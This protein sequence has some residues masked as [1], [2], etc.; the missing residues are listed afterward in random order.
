MRNWLQAF[1]RSVLIVTYKCADIHVCNVYID[2]I[3]SIKHEQACLDGIRFASITNS[4]SILGWSMSQIQ[5]LLWVWV[6]VHQWAK[7]RAECRAELEQF[8]IVCLLDNPEGP[9]PGMVDIFWCAN[10]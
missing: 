1:K 5:A 9:I 2:K 7:I 4:S 3:C 8:A 6:W 10:L